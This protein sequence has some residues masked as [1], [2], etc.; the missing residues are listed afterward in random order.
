[1]NRTGVRV[2]ALCPGATKTDTDSEDIKKGLLSTDYEEA[3]HR[4]YDNRVYQP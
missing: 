2:I 3:Y 4:D 1:M